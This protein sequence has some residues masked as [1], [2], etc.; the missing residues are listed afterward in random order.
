MKIQRLSLAIAL[1]WSAAAATASAQFTIPGLDALRISSSYTGDRD[2]KKDDGDLDLFQI[3]VSAQLTKEPIKPIENFSMIPV[4]SYRYTSMNFSGDHSFP[5][6]DEDLHSIS[7]SSFYIYSCPGSRWIFGGYTGVEL[8]SDFQSIDADDFTG[9]LAGGAA[10]QYNEHFLFGFGAIVANIN[11]DVTAFPVVGFD[12]KVNERM[13]V[14]LYGPL[15]T[16]SYAINESWILSLRGTYQNEQWNIDDATGRSRNIGVSGFK[17][18]LQSDH[19]LADNYW[20]TLGAGYA[21]SNKIELTSSSGSQISKRD[22]EGG[23]YGQIMLSMKT[24]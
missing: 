1:A 22:L 24:W 14:G 13:R 10:Y 9:T 15:L 18:G 11:A 7:A 8:S 3:G 12:W 16:T 20:L 6:E 17:V 5:M 21:F 23:L 2:L 4:M 19:K